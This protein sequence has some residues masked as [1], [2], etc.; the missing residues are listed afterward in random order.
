MPRPREFDIDAVLERA[1]Q[2]FWSKG[3]EATSLDDLC[4]A[5]GLGRSSLYAAFGDKHNLLLQS[6]SRYADNGAERVAKVLMSKVPLRAALSEFLAAFIDAIVA[7]PGRRGCFIGNCAA[8][9]AR[10]DRGAMQEVRKALAR[11]EDYF[12]A[13]LTAAEQRGELSPKADVNALAQ[14][15]TSSIQGLRLVGKANPDREVLEN[16]AAVILR[17]LDPSPPDTPHARNR[18]RA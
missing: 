12:R 10:N 11:N 16:V 17:C 1:M 9:L 14:F 13:A 2:V 3:Y 5:T 4:E 6:L 18:R 8:E 7:G 15:L